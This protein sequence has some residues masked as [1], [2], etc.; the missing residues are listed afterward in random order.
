VKINIGSGDTK[1]EDYVTID[2]DPNSNADIILDLEKE[3]LPFEESTVEAVIAHHILEHLGEGYFHCLQELYR[4]CKHGAVIDIKV[5]HPRHDSFLADPTHRRPITVIGLQMF[6]KKFN[7]LCKE[8]N[9]PT[10]RLG[11]YYNV[12]FEILNFKY[13]PDAKAKIILSELPD[14]QIEE[15]SQQHNNIISEIL[16]QMIVVK[17]AK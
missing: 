4:V 14:N 12:D 3:K 9:C 13:I 16:V 1:Y 7:K 11:E 17:N 2:F 5:P 6:S 10:S 15:Y 8:Q